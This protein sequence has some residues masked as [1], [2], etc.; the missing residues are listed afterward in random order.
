MFAESSTSLIGQ[1]SSCS[2]AQRAT[3]YRTLR[4]HFTK[5]FSQPAAPD[6]IERHRREDDDTLVD[7]RATEPPESGGTRKV[8]LGLIHLQVNKIDDMIS[9]PLASVFLYRVSHV[10]VDWVLLT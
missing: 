7:G 9:W 4:K 5:P 3:A 1:Q 10:L 2:T 6:C 8:G